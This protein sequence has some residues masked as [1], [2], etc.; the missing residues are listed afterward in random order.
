MSLFFLYSMY[1]NKIER[2]ALLSL[3]YLYMCGVCLKL[4]SLFT[5][6]ENSM[7]IVDLSLLLRQ[8]NIG[9][10]LSQQSFC[11]YS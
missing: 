5:Y 10:S 11:V 8:K 6:L 2:L 7:R 3:E 9:F 4:L 1:R